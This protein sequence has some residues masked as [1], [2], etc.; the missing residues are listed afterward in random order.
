MAK[1]RDGRNKNIRR[2]MF[3]RLQMTMGICLLEY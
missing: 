3:L 2:F 1:E